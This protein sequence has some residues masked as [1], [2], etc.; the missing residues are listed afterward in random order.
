MF[1]TKYPHP[2]NFAF[3]KK[4]PDKP[5]TIS[6]AESN[7]GLSIDHHGDSI[8]RLTLSGP[9]PENLSLTQINYPEKT[10]CGP[11]I[12]ES[13][14]LELQLPNGKVLL[15][16]VP[17]AGIGVNN[18]RWI[19]QFR[20]PDSARYY[21]MGEKNFGEI[22][23]SG[24]RTVFWNT[25]VW[26][27]FHWGQW[28]AN[29][30]DPSY[31]ST[32]YVLVKCAQRGFIGILVHNPS[33]VFMETPGKDDSRVFVEWQRTSEHLTIG[34]YDGQPDIWFITGQSVAEV[35]ERVNQLVG[36]TPTPP[37]WS[38]GYHQSRWGYGGEKDLLELDSRFNS[39]RIPCSGLWL[40]LDYMDGFRIF[41]TSPEMFPNG[42]QSVADKLSQS[43]RRIVPI[44]D[45][46]V[47]FEPG[48]RVYDDG[49]Q[50]NVFCKN[51]V[52]SEF[53]G[54][55]WP[56]ETVF[57]DFTKRS[58]WEWWRGYTQEFRDSGF[59]ACWI[60]MN[61][62]STGPADPNDMLFD[63]GKISHAE[64]RNQY[65]LGMQM[66]TYQG[67]LDAIP[68]ERPFILS[69]SGFIGS[70]QYAAIWT[71]DNCSNDF[72]LKL[73]IT[74][75]IGMA[76][77]GHVFNGPDVG[78]FGGDSSPELM[79]RWQQACFLFP[80]CRNHST[81]GT[82]DQEPFAYDGA[83]K[84]NIAHYIR[85]RYKF[86]PYLY[87]LFAQHE[88]T[89]APILRP[90]FYEFDSDGL[91]EVSDQFLVGSNILQAPIIEARSKERDVVLPGDEPWWHSSTGDWRETGTISL[92]VP[93]KNT[94]LFFRAG[95]IVPMQKDLPTTTEIDLRNPRVLITAPRGWLGETSFDYVAD[96]GISF[97]YRDG[98]R[99]TLRITAKGDGTALHIST[100]HTATGFG[101]ITPEFTVVEDV[102]VTI[103]GKFGE[104]TPSVIRLTGRADTVFNVTL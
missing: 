85:L 87:S 36:V 102:P 38:L 29:P 64:H 2:A 8:S 81:A 97:D 67:F 42:V 56:G 12:L 34:A 84:N 5:G 27:D 43:G 101:E 37:L 96:D 31:F 20:V 71:G 57:P 1:F 94:P 70:S 93:M 82:Q 25:D 46:G 30:T 95:A 65:A 11:A 103:N 69:R 52:G 72:Y 16:L 51:P 9:W 54:L 73:S 63:D 68:N 53:V 35:T 15:D 100:E 88:E 45:P 24:Y 32:P 78:G 80:F 44:I 75:S 13:G 33:P 55:V 66:A 98:K 10:S 39:E 58:V 83:A 18:R 77:S 49:H 104:I 76:L 23:L 26:S 74:T 4:L 89:G 3:A 48:Y 92:Q 22:E 14:N 17:E 40:D 28:G 41:Q 99:S 60:D 86:L 61:D 90:L 50:Q 62:P 7:F 21:G 59:G 47:K 19:M 79:T 91:D 6:I